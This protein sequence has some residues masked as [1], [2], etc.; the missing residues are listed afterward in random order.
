MIDEW[1]IFAE[2]GR[3]GS[4][5]WSSPKLEMHTVSAKYENAVDSSDAA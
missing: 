3:M 2:F 5:V 4:S 1:Y